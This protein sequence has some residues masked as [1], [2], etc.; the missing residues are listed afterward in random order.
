M[1]RAA[2]ASQG[3]RKISFFRSPWMDILQFIALMALLIWFM[4]WSTARL[5]YIWHWYRVP[6]FLFS[7][8]EGRLIAGPLI[9]GL[10]LTL[11]ISGLSLVL[12]LALG[13]LTALLRLSESVT[14]RLLS[15]GYLELIRN[16]PLLVQLFVVYFILGP[17]LGMD[18]FTAAVVALTLF[19]G[20]YASEI[21]RAGIVSLHKGQWEAAHSLG[22]NLTDTY[23]FV[24][25]PQAVR[26]ILPPLASQAITLVKDSALVSMIALA[27]LTQAARIVIAQTF[28]SFEIWF[29]T[30]GIYLLVTVSLSIAVR[31]LEKRFHIYT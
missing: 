26:R 18:N 16:T 25:L 23:R 14:G 31:F 28:M 1:E 19:E 9:K 13:L 17:I 12:S 7:R 3:C 11:K 2:S 6:R 5:G 30:A 24:I 10:V 4:S 21:F 29:V 20:A 15:R 27:D 22:L 8:I